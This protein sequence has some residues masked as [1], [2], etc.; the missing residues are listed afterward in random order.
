MFEKYA[1]LPNTLETA[2]PPYMLSLAVGL[3]WNKACIAW[4]WLQAPKKLFPTVR[5]AMLPH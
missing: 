5:A 3:V 2:A 4:E 1:L